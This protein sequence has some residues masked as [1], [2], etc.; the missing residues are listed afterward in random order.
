MAITMIK[1]IIKKWKLKLPELFWILGGAG[2]VGIFGIALIAI[3]VAVDGG[4]AYAVVG[5]FMAVIAGVMLFL[6]MGIFSFGQEFSLALSLGSTRK[7]FLITYAAESFLNIV[8][9]A[10][11][12]GVVGIIEFLTGKICYKQI[13]CSFDFTPYMLDIRFLAG[14]LFLLPALR[15][16]LGA[17]IL[18]F[19]KKAL[20]AFWIVWMFGFA[21]LPKY[22]VFLQKNPEN[23][24]AKVIVGLF[25]T[26]IG[27][28]PVVQTAVIGIAAVLFLAASRLFL[29]RQAII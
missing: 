23:I 27:M 6:L 28:P 18:K 15:I 26:V 3:I 17:L 13:P 2:G 20:V 21:A 16:L 5:T 10:V 24:Q 4:R 9:L 22:A 19:Q 8:L 12:V 25:D 11:T 1:K 7:E 14:A 29:R